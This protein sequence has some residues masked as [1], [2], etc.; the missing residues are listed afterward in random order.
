MNMDDIKR[1]REATGASLSDCKRAL[2][3]AQGDV[4]KALALAQALQETRAHADE[5]LSVEKHDQFE[6]ATDRGA[7]EARDRARLAQREPMAYHFDVVYP[8]GSTYV[9]GLVRG[10]DIAG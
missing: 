10:L 4:D 1:L 5:V 3:D 7:D 2:E 9:E 8:W 6:L